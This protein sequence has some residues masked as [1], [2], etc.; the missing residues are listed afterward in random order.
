MAGT[1]IWDLPT[2]LFHW[3]LALG[4]TAAAVI[5]LALGEHS[6]L[7]PLHAIIGLTLAVMVLLRLVWGF[8]GPR[9]ARF[10]SFAFGPG[11]VLE[12]G[13]GVVM[14]GAKRYVGHNPGSAYAIFAMLLLMGALAV[15]GIMIGRGNEAVKEVHEVCAYA[16]IGVVAAHVLGVAIHTLRHRDNIVAS[17]IHGRKDAQ[18]TDA[19]ASACPIAAIVFLVVAG[20]W[21]LGLVRNY[22]PATRSTVLPVL[23]TT[24][25]LADAED[26]GGRERDAD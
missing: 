3:L 12:Y 18:P 6:P 13:K 9:H 2:R 22:N 19:I 4:F 15:T 20:S 10:S 26:E 16:M 25:Q 24:V 14:G 7:F 23:G 11:A 8:V 17:M 1:L 5:V 21:A